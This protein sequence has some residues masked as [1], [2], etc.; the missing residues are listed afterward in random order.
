MLKDLLSITKPGI[1]VGNLVTVVGGFLLASGDSVNYA[2]L[3]I[4]LLGISSVIASGCVFNNYIDQDIDSVMERTRNRVMVMKRLPGSLVL[5]YGSVLGIAGITLLW[6]QV[7]LLAAVVSVVG[8]FFYVVVYTLWLKRSSVYSTEIGSIAGATPI[9]IGYTA[10]THTLDAVSAI[11]FF[12]LCLWQIPHSYAIAIF[13]FHDYRSASIPVLPVKK[14]IQ[15]T[16]TSIFV[17]ILLFVPCSALL[18]VFGYT[19]LFYMS[20]ALASSTVW[21]WLAWRGWRCLDDEA[22]ARQVF[23]FSIILI[24]VLSVM[25]A[26]G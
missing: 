25:M 4:T 26:I 20:V 21:A 12:M 11:L 7:N 1:I 8:L 13:R 3:M 15:T 19:G 17:Y 9:V 14:G 23:R 5:V 16:K 22:W 24:S 2:L 6:L 10:V 18:T